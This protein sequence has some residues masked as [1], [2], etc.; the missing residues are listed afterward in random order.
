MKTFAE[1]FT[2]FYICFVQKEEKLGTSEVCLS[3]FSVSKHLS[4]FLI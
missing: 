1:N 3:S 2:K 4:I